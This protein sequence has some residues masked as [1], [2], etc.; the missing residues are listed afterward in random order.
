[1]DMALKAKKMYEK[2]FKRVKSYYNEIIEVEKRIDNI[3]LV[4]SVKGT[5]GKNYAKIR[6]KEPPSDN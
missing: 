2:E 6:V 1:M 4:Y 5:K 3:L